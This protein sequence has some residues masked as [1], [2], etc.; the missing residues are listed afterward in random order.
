MRGWLIQLPILFG[1]ILGIRIQGPRTDTENGPV[2]GTYEKSYTGF[3]FLSFRGIPY[4]KPPTGENRFKVCEP[5]KLIRVH[6]NVFKEPQRLKAK[7]IGEWD[8]RNFGS[9]CLQLNHFARA[10]S[11]AENVKY[12][13]EG[14]EDC[15]FL[16]I[17][18]REDGS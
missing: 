13:I 10:D 8:A 4:A 5:N 16:N 9:A 18:T 15:L 2:I 11:N 17:Y 6:S 12:G 7:W 1:C 14:S 3:D